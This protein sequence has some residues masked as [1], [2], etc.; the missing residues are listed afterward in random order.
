MRNRVFEIVVF[1]IDYMQGDAARLSD[2]DDL[3]AT[4]ESQ[5][6]SEDEI[7]S[8][9]S[10]LLKR[11]ENHPQRY[12]SSFPATPSSHRVLTASERSQLTTEAYGFLIKLSNTSVLSDEQFETI[13]NRLS[14]FGPMPVTL[15]QIKLLASSVVFSELD[16]FDAIELFDSDGDHTSFVN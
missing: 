5:G 15:D 13:M 16:E 11:F 9:Y 12:F 8:A 6:Y 3:W 10:W 4:L 1:L 2:T 7:S 14:A